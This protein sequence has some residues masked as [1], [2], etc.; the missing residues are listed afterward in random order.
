MK[1]LNVPRNT[2]EWD[3]FSLEVDSR[4]PF[5]AEDI[6]DLENELEEHE[7]LNPTIEL[8]DWL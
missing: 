7:Q 3:Y 2:E 6:A 1:H 8:E 5:T 4:E